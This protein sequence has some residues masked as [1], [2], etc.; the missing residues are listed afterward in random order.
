MESKQRTNHLWYLGE[1]DA[2]INHV[3]MVWS[4][5]D[6]IKPFPCVSSHWNPS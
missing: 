4:Q 3:L 1:Q 5:L 6:G 2:Y